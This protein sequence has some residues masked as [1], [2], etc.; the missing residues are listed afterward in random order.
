MSKILV[1]LSDEEEE[2][3]ENPQLVKT[4]KKRNGH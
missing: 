2:V 3:I 4:S 1:G